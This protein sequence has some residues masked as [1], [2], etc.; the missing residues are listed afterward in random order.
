MQSRRDTIGLVAQLEGISQIEAFK[1]LD[2]RYNLGISARRGTQ[3]SKKK[4]SLKCNRW[5]ENA[6]EVISWFC[7][8]CWKY[9]YR[10]EG[11]D[12]DLKSLCLTEG[13]KAEELHHIIH[14]EL[15]PLE[16]YQRFRKEV[17]AY[18]QLYEEFGGEPEFNV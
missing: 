1:Q 10:T 14:D 13:K 4:V 8:V 3:E 6:L 18:E 15:P 17:G 7:R 11:I 9:G 5:R 12:E 2:N 16:S